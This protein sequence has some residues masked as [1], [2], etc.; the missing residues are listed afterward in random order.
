[1]ELHGLGRT[2]SI[3]DATT[4][5]LNAWIDDLVTSATIR[6]AVDRMQRQFLEVEGSDLGADVVEAV[7]RR[8]PL[9]PN[10]PLV[11]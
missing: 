9:P 7:A 3:D 10:A 6:T 8:S 11:R 4:L 5:R 2:G 1:V